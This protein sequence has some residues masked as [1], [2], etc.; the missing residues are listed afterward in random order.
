MMRKYF[1]AHYAIAANGEKVG[2]Y[3][4]Y[5]FSILGKAL[6]WDMFIACATPGTTIEIQIRN[7]E[8][9][10]TVTKPPFIQL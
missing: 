6:A 1:R 8:E 10:A 9:K 3:K 4:R 5:N 7:T 2:G